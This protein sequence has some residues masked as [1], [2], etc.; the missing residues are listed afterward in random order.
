MTKQVFLWKGYGDIAVYAA[1]T[2]EQIQDILTTVYAVALQSTTVT[3]HCE[4][5]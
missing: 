5:N 1:D 3:M 2:P 4:R